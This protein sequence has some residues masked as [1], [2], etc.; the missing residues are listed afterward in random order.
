MVTHVT[1]IIGLILCLL[2]QATM[3]VCVHNL[4]MVMKA[5]F[6]TLRLSSILGPIILRHQLPGPAII[7]RLL[8]HHHIRL[9]LCL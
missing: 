9:R 4:V 8:Q 6:S 1:A 7:T 3:V 2:Q 5:Y